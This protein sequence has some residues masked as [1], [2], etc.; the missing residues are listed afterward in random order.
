MMM[1]G[2]CDEQ[3]IAGSPCPALGLGGLVVPGQFGARPG[4]DKQSL[5]R[6]LLDGRP[7]A[8]NR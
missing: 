6:S 3:R 7:P 4:L 8:E 2:G 1:L 5:S